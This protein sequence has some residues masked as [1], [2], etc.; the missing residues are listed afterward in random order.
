MNWHDLDDAPKETLNRILWWDA[1][2]YDKEYPVLKKT[3]AA[4]VEE[5]DR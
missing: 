1:K 4:E 5:R 2:G 3:A